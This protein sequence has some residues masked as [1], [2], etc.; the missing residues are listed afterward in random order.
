MASSNNIPI[1]VLVC[2]LATFVGLFLVGVQLAIGYSEERRTHEL[3]QNT[4]CLV[5]DHALI[6]YTKTECALINSRCQSRKYI[7]DEHFVSYITSNGTVIN[8]TVRSNDYFRKVYY[9]IC[10]TNKNNCN[11]SFYRLVLIINVF[12]IKTMQQL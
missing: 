2:T 5:T 11:I 4:N 6:N 9:R 8:S 12:I 3:Y 10:M 7:D 1:L